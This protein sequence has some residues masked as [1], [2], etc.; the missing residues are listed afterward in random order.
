MKQGYVLF[1]DKL[2]GEYK[3]VFKQVEMYS[4]SHL[5]GRDTDSELLMELLDLL[6]EAQEANIPVT[7]IVGD[8]VETFC[9]NFFSEYKTSNRF[10]DMLKIIYQMAWIVFVFGLLDLFLFW[11]EEENSTLGNTQIGAVMVGFGCGMVV[12]G[13]VYF[14]LRP[15]VYKYKK[16][17]LKTFH[18]MV[19]ALTVSMVVVSFVLAGYFPVPV[20]GWIALGITGLYIGIYMIVRMVHN[21]K[22]YGCLKEPRQENISFQKE[23]KE[24]VKKGMPEEWLK[25]LQKKNERR[26]KKGQEPLTEQEYL[27]KLDKE[28]DYKRMQL[29]NALIFGGCALVA[30]IGT[31]VFDGFESAVDALIFVLLIG[32]MEG[33]L[34]LFFR[35]ITKTTSGLYQAMRSKMQAESLTLEQYVEKYKDAE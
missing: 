14:L 7:K 11:G 25:Q 4:T 32:V 26:R 33:V 12:N 15:L 31:A 28:Y 10:L 24:S 5:I 18:G 13:I 1:E 17:K 27:Q 16:M 35:K 20:P 23:I 30:V 8:N 22:K 19:T 21:Y 6:L 3:Q 34:Y 2:K 9:G 29:M